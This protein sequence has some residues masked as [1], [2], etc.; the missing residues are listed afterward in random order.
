MSPSVGPGA[1][2]DDIYMSFSTMSV[3]FIPSNTFFNPPMLTEKNLEGL[4]SQGLT[5]AGRWKMTEQPEN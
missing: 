3:C 2:I 5:R 1:K 4:G